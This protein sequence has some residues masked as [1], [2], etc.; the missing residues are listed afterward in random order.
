[1]LSLHQQ[2]KSMK[3]IKVT[4]LMSVYNG[5]Q[6]LPQSIESILNQTYDNYEFIIIDDASTDK[7]YSILEKYASLHSQIVLIKNEKNLGL[8][9]SLNL[10]IKMS[11]GKY[12]ARQ[13]HDD[14]SHPDRLEKEVSYLDQNRDVM[15]VTGNLELIDSLGMFIKHTK[16]FMEQKLIA[17]YLL[18]YN[19]IGGHSLVMFRKENVV[20]LGGYNEAFP[21]G[22]DYQL[23]LRLVESGKLVILPD[24]L[25]QWRQHDKSISAKKES[26]QE[27]LGLRC[28][29]NS[30]SQLIG[31]DII[32]AR[33]IELRDFWL[34]NLS[35]DIKVRALHKYLKRIYKAY[36]KKHSTDVPTHPRL[37][38][39]LRHLIGKQ[40]ISCEKSLSF[41]ISPLFNLKLL[42]YAIRWKPIGSIA[43]CIFR[44]W[45]ILLEVMIKPTDQ[46]SESRF[47]DKVE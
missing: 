44:P 6:Y 14:I 28:T 35:T 24:V 37:A 5:E 33:A 40:F 46:I 12:I 11:R 16:R 13:D 22:Q 15:L 47:Y 32:R 30:I 8:T 34:H 31:E 17:W 18:F 7:S 10:G 26:E 2:I 36:L 42:F 20:S 27:T 19:V 4:V 29:Q 45:Q 38:T 25:L 39:V 3:S 43:Y 1:V 23:W 9:K 21:F 41:K